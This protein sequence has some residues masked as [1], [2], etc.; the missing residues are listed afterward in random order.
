MSAVLC[1][2]SRWLSILVSWWE[3]QRGAWSVV[4]SWTHIYMLAFINTRHMHGTLAN[5]GNK[6]VGPWDTTTPSLENGGSGLV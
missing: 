6:D 3:G 4:G 1:C 2:T 5:R